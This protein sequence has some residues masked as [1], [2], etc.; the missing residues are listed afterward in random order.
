MTAAPRSV[1]S[2]GMSGG[3]GFSG[4]GFG[5]AAIGLVPD[6]V[7]E[8]A[9]HTVRAVFADNGIAR[10]VPD[11]DRHAET[12]ALEFAATHGQNRVAQREAQSGAS[13]QQHGATDEPGRFR[14]HSKCEVRV[15]GR[16]EAK[17]RLAPATKPLATY[18]VKLRDGELFVRI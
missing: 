7:A 16:E 6:A 1:G 4:G 2:S 10:V 17:L 8:D 15:L 11:F 5:G 18:P 14:P 12:A 13:E 3:G 9:A